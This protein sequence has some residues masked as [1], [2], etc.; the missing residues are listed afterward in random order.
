M[1]MGPALGKRTDAAIA[2][3]WAV[4]SFDDIGDM[5]AAYVV[6]TV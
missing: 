2:A 1:L 6:P 3:G 5:M 4:A